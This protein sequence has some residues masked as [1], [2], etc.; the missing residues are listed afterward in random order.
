MDFAQSTNVGA[1][2]PCGFHHQSWWAGPSSTPLSSTCP[3]FFTTFRSRSPPLQAESIAG[4]N[5]VSVWQCGGV[6]GFATLFLICIIRGGIWWYD[7]Q[8][9]QCRHDDERQALANAVDIWEGL[10]QIPDR[11]G[12]P[13]PQIHPPSIDHLPVTRG[14]TKAVAM[15]NLCVLSGPDVNLRFWCFEGTRRKFDAEFFT[16]FSPISTL[17]IREL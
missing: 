15:P 10:A 12:S 1:G 8:A 11:R 4:P 9:L 7:A 2:F 5:G 16:S 6:N 13:T 14:I 17:R 3:T